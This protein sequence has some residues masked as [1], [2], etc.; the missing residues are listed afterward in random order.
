MSSNSPSVPL[1]PDGEK[2]DGTRFLGFKTTI[3]ALAKA[4]G[5]A[6]YLDGTLP[7]P[8]PPPAGAG[9]PVPTAMTVVL[10]P[11][12]TPIYSMSPSPE[13]WKHHDAFAYALIVLNSKNPIGLGLKLDGSA[14]DAM[15]SL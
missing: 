10:P 13:E 12:P 5:V 15:K 7:D 2:F 9:A 3:Y 6:S 4:R 14:H 1:L 11:D 8:S